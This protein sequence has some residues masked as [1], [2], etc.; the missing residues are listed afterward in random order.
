M[1]IDIQIWLILSSVTLTKLI[2]ISVKNGGEE[3]WLFDDML[4]N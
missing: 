1:N 3:T 2:Y 4:W